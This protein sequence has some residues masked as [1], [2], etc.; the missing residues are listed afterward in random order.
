MEVRGFDGLVR[1]EQCGQPSTWDRWA[2]AVAASL[3]GVVLVLRVS[4]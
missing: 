3:F 2:L 1:S 4:F